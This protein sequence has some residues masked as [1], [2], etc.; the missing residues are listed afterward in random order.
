[1]TEN[2]N[3]MVQELNDDFRDLKL[4]MTKVMGK[5]NFLEKVNDLKAKNDSLKGS[6]DKLKKVK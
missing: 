6:L 5:N 2:K 4:F 1:M 3:S